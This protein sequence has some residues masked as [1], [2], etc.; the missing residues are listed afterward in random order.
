[1][2]KHKGQKAKNKS[3]KAKKAQVPLGPGG[4]LSKKQKMMAN[5]AIVASYLQQK[6]AHGA[7]QWLVCAHIK[8]RA[9]AQL[10]GVTQ[11]RC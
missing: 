8:L 9:G 11:M 2:A 7:A 3:K 6:K 5:K 1:M 4:T 10:L